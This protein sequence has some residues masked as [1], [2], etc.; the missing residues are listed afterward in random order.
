M[1]GELMALDIPPYSESVPSLKPPARITLIRNTISHIQQLRSQEM[2]LDHYATLHQEDVSRLTVACHFLENKCQKIKCACPIMK[3]PHYVADHVQ[4]SGQLTSMTDHIARPENAGSRWVTMGDSFTTSINDGINKSLGCHPYEGINAIGDVP[5]QSTNLNVPGPSKANRSIT[6]RTNKG[7]KNVKASDNQ[8]SFH[9]NYGHP[10]WKSGTG[11]ENAGSSSRG[12]NAGFNSGNSTTVDNGGFNLGNST[13]GENGY[14][15]SGSY[16]ENDKI[17]STKGSDEGYTYNDSILESDAGYDNSQH[18][19]AVKANSNSSHDQNLHCVVSL[20]RNGKTNFITPA[21]V[22]MSSSER[23]DS[24]IVKPTAVSLSQPAE[25]SITPAMTNYLKSPLTSSESETYMTQ[26]LHDIVLPDA[27]EKASLIRELPLTNTGMI[28]PDLTTAEAADTADT[29]QKMSRFLN[30][31]TS[32]TQTDVTLPVATDMALSSATYLIASDSSYGTPTTSYIT[33]PAVTCKILPTATAITPTTSNLTSSMTISAT[34]VTPAAACLTQTTTGLTPPA[35]YMIPSNATVI[36]SAASDLTA[37]SSITLSATN[38]TPA[39]IGFKPYAIGGTSSGAKDTLSPAVS[40]V[41]RPMIYRKHSERQT[42]SNVSSHSRT[43]ALAE[44][45]NIAKSRKTA[46]AATQECLTIKATERMLPTD[47]MTSDANSPSA[48]PMKKFCAYH[49][50]LPPVVRRGKSVAQRLTR[51]SICMISSS[52]TVAN[53]TVINSIEQLTSRLTAPAVPQISAPLQAVYASPLTAIMTTQASTYVP[54]PHATSLGAAFMTSPLLAFFLSSSLSNMTVP[55]AT[56]SVVHLVPCTTDMRTPAGMYP[57]STEETHLD[58][59]GSHFKT[60]TA[61]RR[62][63]PKANI[64]TPD[65]DIKTPDVD[66]KTPDVDIKTPDV[67]VKT[68]DI[69]GTRK[70]TYSKRTFTEVTNNY[71]LFL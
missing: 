39:V 35:T 15:H 56:Q 32:T 5:D 65:V 67:D 3:Y 28:T 4:L 14:T 21:S 25:T 6:K 43:T 68:P 33:Q 57:R 8:L 12:D 54:A 27:T 40:E 23:S 1:Y 19:I 9:F 2:L 10:I 63:A 11:Y 44:I 70:R 29:T 55:T 37:S 66:I 41:I 34:G 31:M 17:N 60:P 52:N 18:E 46:V 36:T 53:K 7:V 62:I 61:K 20:T 42:K 30:D 49:M 24:V 48:T 13:K 22:G 16:V 45:T 50:T 64:K 51:A 69:G 47:H 71:I 59:S 38:V 26:S 58:T